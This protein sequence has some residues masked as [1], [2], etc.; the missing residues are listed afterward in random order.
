VDDLSIVAD[1]IIVVVLL[2]FCAF[3][4]G[5]ETALTAFSRERMFGLQKQGKKAAKKALHLRENK[6]SLLGT[7]LLGNTMV[8]AGAS[9]FATMIA[10][11]FFGENGIA[12]ATLGITIL[13]LVFGEVLPKTYALEHPERVSLR[14][15]SIM[16]LFV[17]VFSPVTFFVHHIID[18]LMKVM[19][20]DGD[21]GTLI[22]GSDVI[23]GAIELQHSEGGMEGHEKHMLGAVLDLNDV[24]VGDVIVHRKQ[25]Y[26]LDA[27]LP[28]AQLLVQIQQS[29]HS[30][31]PFWRD[32][33]DNIIGL[34]HVRDVMSMA[35][36]KGTANI[37]SE[38]ILACLT[39]PWFVPETTPLREQLF[40]FRQQ[41][42]HFAYVVDEYGAFLGIVTLEDIIEEIVGEIE[43]EYDC[44][45]TVGIEAYEH[46]GYMIEGTVTIRD[47]NRH[48][49][50]D[51]PEDE[52]STIAGLVIHHARC[53]PEIGAE[54]MF[55]GY[56]FRVKKKKSNQLLRVLVQKV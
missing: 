39:Q 55:V 16:T 42:K 35:L 33:P 43:D 28:V 17:K 31:I 26:M 53:I 3:F 34:L 6:E 18:F 1:A 36:E 40:A 14:V 15:A 5:S 37:T 8:I 30:R 49:D 52:A 38:M 46:G 32:D 4:S 54:F 48:L 21:S 11:Q 44:T 27:D 51:L 12:F 41:R 47:I 20:L 7:I 56:R 19:R 50:W 13:V 29:I 25:L 9:S 10:M 2:I 23:R 24:C 22:S 45:R